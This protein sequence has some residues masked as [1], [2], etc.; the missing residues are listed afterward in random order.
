MSLKLKLVKKYAIKFAEKN[1]VYIRIGPCTFK[2]QKL[3]TIPVDGRLYECS[4]TIYLANGLDLQA[5]FRIRKTQDP[6]LIED[7]IYTK[8]DDVWYKLDEPDFYK[9][10]E[11]EANDIYPITWLPD[12]PL[13]TK[14]EG[15]YTLDWKE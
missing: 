11:L 2:K 9:K 14:E 15:P 7:S 8:I 3:L 5:S 4:G 13:Q 6:L 1:E 12:I 10:T